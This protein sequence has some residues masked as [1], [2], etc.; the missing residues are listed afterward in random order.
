MRP[1]FAT[2]R[3]IGES[4]AKDPGGVPRT[5]GDTFRMDSYAASIG[6]PLGPFWAEGEGPNLMSLGHARGSIFVIR[7]T[8]LL[9]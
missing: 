9:S 4:L 5:S 2:A 1:A 7:L 6:S 3:V 8:N